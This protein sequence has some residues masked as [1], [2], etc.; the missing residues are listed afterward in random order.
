MAS[1]KSTAC[2]VTKI[3]SIE[4]KENIKY[5]QTEK[6]ITQIRLIKRVKNKVEES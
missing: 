1:S 5:N 4:P 6:Q 3:S 2:R